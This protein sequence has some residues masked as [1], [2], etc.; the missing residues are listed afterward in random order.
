MVWRGFA[1]ILADGTLGSWT[2]L[3]TCWQVV[4]PWERAL[5]RRA[6]SLH[7]TDTLLS[8]LVYYFFVWFGLGWGNKVLLCT[9]TL[10]VGQAGFKFQAVF[11]SQILWCLGL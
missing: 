7:G 11:L 8:G 1:S 2:A 9:G 3:V 4:R 10:Y 5:G 6:L